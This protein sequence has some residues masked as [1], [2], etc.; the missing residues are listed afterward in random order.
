MARKISDTSTDNVVDINSAPKRSRGR[1]KGS[2]NKA[3]AEAQRLADD[4]NRG[5]EGPQVAAED[6]GETALGNSLGIGHNGHPELTPGIFLRWVQRL[7]QHEDKGDALK[8]QLKAW[9]TERKLL[10]KEA[11]GDGIVLG[12]MDEALDDIKTE[13]VDILARE[14]R[15]RDY[16]AWLGIPF[17]HPQE[18]KDLTD[19]D[20]EAARWKRR[21]DQDGRLGK[22]REVPDGCPPECIAPYLSGH[23]EGTQVLMQRLPLTREGFDKDGAVKTTAPAPTGDGGI[24]ILNEGHFAAGTA[25]EDANLKTLLAEHHEAFMAA[26]RVVALYGTRRRVLKEDDYLDDGEPDTDLTESEAVEDAADGL[27]TAMDLA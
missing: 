15:R 5:L 13:S 2:A 7:N 16:H 20:R 27:P 18:M 24:L 4:L 12:Q 8:L 22:V 11:N 9:R 1:P 19:P 25:L 10:R 3:K 6:V 26:D 23:D 17:E 21:G 14:D